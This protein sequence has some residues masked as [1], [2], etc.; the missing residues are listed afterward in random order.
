LESQ[1]ERVEREAERAYQQISADLRHD[2]GFSPSLLLFTTRADLDRG[3]TSGTAQGRTDSRTRILLSFDEPSDRLHGDLVHEI[4]HSFEFDIVPPSILNTAPFWIREGLTQYE[5]GEWDAGDRAM[6]SDL[7]RTN[8]VLRMSQ[9]TPSSFPGDARLNYSLGQAAFEFIASRWDKEGVRR[10]LA[11]LRRSSS[12]D[13]KNVYGTAFGLTP[14]DFDRAFD[15]Y[16][17]ARFQ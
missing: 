4:T 5:R 9:L 10:F 17:H 7:V 6:L 12:D 2:L 11:A 8:T 13:V 3:L 16:L 14:D 15:D 1:L